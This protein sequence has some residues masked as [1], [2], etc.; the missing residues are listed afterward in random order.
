MPYVVRQPPRTI[1]NFESGV[2]GFQGLAD[3]LL[4]AILSGQLSQV[5]QGRVAP[6][7]DIRNLALSGGRQFSGTAGAAKRLIPQ[8]I[9][10]FQNQVN[11]GMIP[12]SSLPAGLGFTPT[13][14]SA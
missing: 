5:P 10:G 11:R 13:G 1:G 3:I 8:D 12:S 6:T 9:Q 14:K 2:Q 4:Q 7:G